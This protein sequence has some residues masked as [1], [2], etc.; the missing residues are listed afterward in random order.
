MPTEGVIPDPAKQ[1]RAGR[2]PQILAELLELEA[3]LEGDGES[4]SPAF[5]I[6]GGSP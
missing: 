4:P 1:Y 3:E 6:D 5:V 2:A